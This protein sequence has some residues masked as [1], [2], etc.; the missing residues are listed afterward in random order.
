MSVKIGAKSVTASLLEASLH[1]SNRVSD[2]TKNQLEVIIRH[3]K[4][5][6][7]LRGFVVPALES[8]LEALKNS[9]VSLATCK[10]MGSIQGM[11]LIVAQELD[12]L[13][14]ATQK[15]SPL[16]PKDF[17]VGNQLQQIHPDVRA[18]TEEMIRELAIT[19]VKYALSVLSPEEIS[20]KEEQPQKVADQGASAA[21]SSI[22]VTKATIVQEQEEDIVYVGTTTNSASTNSVR[23][24][25]KGGG[26]DNEVPIEVVKRSRFVDSYETYTE[27][28]KAAIETAQIKLIQDYME[29]T[30]S[31][32][33]GYEE[34]AEA[35]SET[36]GTSDSRDYLNSIF[37]DNE[38]LLPM[39]EDDPALLR[40]L[41][42]RLSQDERFKNELSKLGVNLKNYSSIYDDILGQESSLESTSST[43]AGAADA[44]QQPSNQDWK[45]QLKTAFSGFFGEKV[46]IGLVDIFNNDDKI[47]GLMMER[48]DQLNKKGVK[49]KAVILVD[50][51]EWV[52][53]IKHQLTFKF[54]SGTY[55]EG[56]EE[57]AL[58]E[59]IENLFYSRS[60]CHVLFARLF[61]L[62][63]KKEDCINCLSH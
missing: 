38:R 49:D 2:M 16:L 4:D 35:L 17:G 36:K 26:D 18:A 42:L 6:Q 28:Q 59:S 23:Q 44:V 63:I 27:A 11:N 37:D 14:K 33:A 9:T 24:K 31:T 10:D 54:Y 58:K 45:V 3:S 50:L 46:N 32:T 7:A 1:I 25:R 48:L 62:G 29:K 34:C 5:N 52:K 13:I 61:S 56:T 15:D 41:S 19:R 39:I 21:E 22:S 57:A 30:D 53:C 60:C 47:V 40:G 43:G 20:R 8:I 55:A 51:K 12:G